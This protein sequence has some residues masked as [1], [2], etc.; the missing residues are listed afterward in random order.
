[1]GENVPLLLLNVRYT[2]V[3]METENPTRWRN[4]DLYATDEDMDKFVYLINLIV[5]T[6][7]EFEHD[8]PRSGRRDIKA[9]W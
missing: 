9:R 1:M 6:S 5:G 2:N 4:W 3:K 7:L 8:S